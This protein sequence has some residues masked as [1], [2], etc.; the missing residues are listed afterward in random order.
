M[1]MTE[2]VL[3]ST[4]AAVI[5]AT[6]GWLFAWVTDRLHGEDSTQSPARGLLL[7]DPLVRGRSAVVWA[8]A[9]WLV[10]GEW[11]RWVATGALA[12]PLIQVAVTGLRYRYV[13]TVIAVLGLFLGLAFGYRLQDAAWWTSPVPTAAAG[14][15]IF[16]VVYLLGRLPYRVGS[17][18]RAATSPSRP[19]LAR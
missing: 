19:W 9:P 4:V 3:V 5:G 15:L 14:G 13:Y 7:R 12:L 16:L 6:L 1:T 18:L 8:T 11:W 17:H 2:R 10:D